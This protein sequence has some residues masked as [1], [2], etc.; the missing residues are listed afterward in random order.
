MGSLGPERHSNGHLYKQTNNK[1]QQHSQ[2]TLRNDMIQPA[3]LSINNS[4]WNLA[5][6]SATGTAGLGAQSSSLHLP[7]LQNVSPARFP[8]RQRRTQLLQ[9]QRLRKEFFN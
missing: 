2:I 6:N 5:A 3:I 7:P 1:L 4:A 8:E 9:K